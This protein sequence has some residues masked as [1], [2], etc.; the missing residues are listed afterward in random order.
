M[1]N[2]RRWDGLSF[3]KLLACIVV[4]LL[5]C[6]LPGLIG[7]A[8]IYGLRFSVP[9]F[10]MI[11][12]YFAFGRPEA[13]LRKKLVQTIRTTVIVEALYAVWHVIHDLATASPVSLLN[14]L[15]PLTIVKKL[16]FG[17]FVNGTMWYMYAL[18]YT[19]LI[20]WLLTR[21]GAVRAAY[22]AIIPLLLVQI[23]GRYYV[24][25]HFDIEK[26]VF[27]FCSAPLFGLPFVLL[28]HWVRAHETRLLAR[29]TLVRC[30]LLALLSGVLIAAEYVLSG[31]YMDLH[32]SS[33]VLSVALLLGALNCPEMPG[34]MQPAVWAGRELSG[35]TYFAHAFVISLVELVLPAVQGTILHPLLGVV[36]SFAL[37]WVISAAAAALRQHRAA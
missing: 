32:V 37:A 34:W 5:H 36:L 20:L 35:M 15:S 12:G 21:R 2:Q 30:V 13:W 9:C 31:Q 22:R 19:W 7:D 24:Q 3:L 28:G 29:M 11:S 26:F 17:T 25:N 14:D 1:E 33:V 16:L 4:I 27:L 18:I 8:V 23:F 10:F 6:P